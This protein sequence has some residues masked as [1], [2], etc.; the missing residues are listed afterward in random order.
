MGV[1]L[2]LYTLLFSYLFSLSNYVSVYG[3]QCARLALKGFL[4]L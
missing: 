3:L 2:A 4:L 1:F